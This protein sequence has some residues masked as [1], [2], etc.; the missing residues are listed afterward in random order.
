MP[1][2]IIGGIVLFGLV[3]IWFGTHFHW[4]I[5]L[6]ALVGLIWFNNT[7]FIRKYEIGALVPLVWRIFFCLGMLVGDINYRVQTD[8]NMGNLLDD[9]TNLFEVKQE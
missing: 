9:V 2:L 8:G 7:W 1:V 3:G 6:A 5:E 4:V